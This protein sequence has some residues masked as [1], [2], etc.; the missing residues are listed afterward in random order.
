MTHML[1][2]APPYRLFLEVMRITLLICMMIAASTLLAGTT[3]Y[4]WV[5]EQGRV[6]YSDQPQPNADEIEVVDPMSFDPG[7]REQASPPVQE[8]KPEL[9]ADKAPATYNFVGITAPTP[10]QVLWNIG[11]VLS[12]NVAVQ[13]SLV[14]GH[15]I[16]VKYDDEEI[17]DW[18]SNSKKHE[19]RNVFRG[20]HTVSVSVTDRSGEEVATGTPVTFYVKQTSVLN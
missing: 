4:R 16:V 18:P 10:D 6:H 13:P 5:D 1:V 3:L 15:R 12:V 19:I 11:G 9:S 7:T 8:P 17:D 2:T 20:T 14:F